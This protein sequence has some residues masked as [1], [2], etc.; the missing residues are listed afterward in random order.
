[1]IIVLLFVMIRRILYSSIVFFYVFITILLNSYEYYSNRKKLQ[2]IAH[3]KI[4]SV[5]V[6]RRDKN[7]EETN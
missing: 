2:H 1:M 3:P 6:K 5:L 4:S 7:G